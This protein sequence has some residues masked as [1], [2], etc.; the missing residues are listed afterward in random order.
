MSF[1]TRLS[2]D[3]C[4]YKHTL[5]QSVGSADYILNT[6]RTDCKPCLSSDPSVRM[7]NSVRYSEGV[8]VCNN[9]PLVDVDSELKLLTRRASDCPSQKYIPTGKPMC[10]MRHYESCTSTP[11][12]EDTRLSNPPCTMRSTGWNRWEWLC[13]NP[14]EKALIPFDFN[15]NNRLI[16]KDNHRPCVPTPI[17]QAPCLPALNGVDNVVEYNPE[18]C[19]KPTT[20]TQSTSWRK[21]GTYGGYGM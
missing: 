6:P 7:S 10:T 14:Q 15:I 16:V 19:M 3:A 21:C 5:K 11:P 18:N 8:S 20:E 17:N 12:Q 1:N 4:A 13:K 9:I 2:Y